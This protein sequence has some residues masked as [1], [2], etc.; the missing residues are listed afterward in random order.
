MKS[1]TD[2]MLNVY[3]QH[4]VSATFKVNAFTLSHQFGINSI[5]VKDLPQT[6]I[7]PC[8]EMVVFVILHLC[9]CVHDMQ[10]HDSDSHCSIQTVTLFDL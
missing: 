5:S 8:I 3:L 4:A 1:R 9:K 6:S 2:S 7:I 10:H